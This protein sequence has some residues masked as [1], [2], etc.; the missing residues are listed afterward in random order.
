MKRRWPNSLR[1]QV[2]AVF[3]CVRAI[4]KSKEEAPLDI[5]SLRTWEEYQ[6]ECLRL[7]DFL[8]PHGFADILDAG[9]MAEGMRQY[10]DLTLAQLACNRRSLQTLEK[11]LAAFSKLEYAVNR[12]LELHS[13]D[14]PRLDT[15][16]VR[17]ECRAR[18]GLELQ[19]N[20]TAYDDRAYPEPYGLIAA[21]EDPTHQ[22][23]ALLQL[24]GGVRAEGS[25]APRGHLKNP[26][27]GKALLGECD[28]PVTGERCGAIAT[29][30]KGGKVTTHFLPLGTYAHLQEYLERYGQ[31]E[32]D[33]P[34]YLASVNRAARATHQH[35]SGRGSHGLKHNFARKRY[36][37]C[38]RH[39]MTQEQAL[40]QV[41]LEAGHF[42]PKETFTYTL[43]RRRP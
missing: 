41:S 19:R 9:A 30:E 34:A 21:I 10:L 2:L 24:E 16:A 20:S 13:L 23:Q 5:R 37:Q 27:T 25:G 36:L 14:I 40:L 28:D 1:C 33:Y 42:R 39:G 6:Y 3:H 7:V 22:L 35:I 43:G 15:L 38:A 8:R 12:Y 11:M 4:G 31:L 18:A 32:S 29:R 26:L 17:R